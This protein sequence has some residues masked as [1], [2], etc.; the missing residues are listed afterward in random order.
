MHLLDITFID[1][2]TSGNAKNW[3]SLL[4]G[5][6]LLCTSLNAENSIS[7]QEF[8]KYMHRQGILTE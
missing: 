5:L 4:L 1:Y 3:P 2:Y 7:K 8:F 6:C